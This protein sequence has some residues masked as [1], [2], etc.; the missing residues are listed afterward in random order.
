MAAL[1]NRPVMFCAASDQRTPEAGTLN[2]RFRS[3]TATAGLTSLQYLP[4][5]T[6]KT[7]MLL[8]P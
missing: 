2:G 5:E 8:G 7:S 6:W 3:V 4:T 1:G